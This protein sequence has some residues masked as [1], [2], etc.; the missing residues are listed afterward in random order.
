MST[1][2]SR[3][4][5]IHQNWAYFW[6]KLDPDPGGPKTYPDPQLWS[7]G[8][9]KTSHLRL[10]ELQVSCARWAESTGWYLSLNHSWFLCSTKNSF[11]FC[12]LNSSLYSPYYRL[13]INTKQGLL[14]GKQSRC[15][16]KKNPPFYF[17][18]KVMDS[19]CVSE[20]KSD[21]ESWLSV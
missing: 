4:E 1:T 2:G 13:E 19:E 9:W 8:T 12:R 21:F 20:S 6:D 10:T 18:R 15:K 11:N 16:N 3:S 14:T 17:F 7:Q 5:K